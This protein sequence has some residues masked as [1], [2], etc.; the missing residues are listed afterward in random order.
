MRG[1]GGD[2]RRFHGRG[3]VELV[4]TGVGSRV[5]ASAKCYVTH[6]LQVQ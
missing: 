1:R 4:C 6:W 5:I 2:G 3:G